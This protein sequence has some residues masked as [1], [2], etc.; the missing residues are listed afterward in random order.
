[1]PRV[2]FELTIPASKRA[3]TVHVLD[4]SA[5]VTGTISFGF[6][7]MG[8]IFLQQRNRI[9]T[10]SVKLQTTAIGPFRMSQKFHEEGTAS[11]TDF[12]S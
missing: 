3:K 7:K 10:C 6:H 11:V 12:M 9:S 1:M 5:T 4:Y 2:G 8:D